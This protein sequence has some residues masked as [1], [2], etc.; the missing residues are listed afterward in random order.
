MP[1]WLDLP[2]KVRIYVSV[3]ILAAVPILFHALKVVLFSQQDYFWVILTA[4]TLVM[5]PFS[6]SH[7]GVRSGV[8]IGD[9]FVIS[10]CMLYQV[11]SAVVA[12]I[13]YI[14]YLALLLRRRHNT[15]THRIIFNIATA[16]INVQLYGAVYKSLIPIDH[17]LLPTF[18]LAVTFFLSNSILIAIAISLSSNTKFFDVWRKNY[19]PLTLD[20]LLSACGGA[21]IYLFRNW[22]QAAPLLVAPFVGAVW[23][24]NNINRAKAVDAQ[25]RL[26]EQ[27]RHSEEQEQ[28]YLRTVETLALAVDAKDQTTYGHI[29][30][31]KAYALGLAK[32]SGVSDPNEL[33]AIET[34]ALLHDIGKLAIEDYILNKPGRLSRQEFEKMKLHATAGDEI[35]RQVQFPFPVAQ[36]VRFHHERWDGTGYPD[37]LKGEEIPVG[38]R[39]LSIADAFD[40]IRSTRPYKSAFGIDDSLE[41]LRSQAGSSYDPRLVH[42]FI[43]HIDELESAADDAARNVS[44][45]SFRKYFETV[46]NAVT[47]TDATLTVDPTSASSYEE[48]VQLVEFCT[49]VGRFLP[50]S[51]SLLI[52]ARRL[53]KIVL[54]DTCAFYVYQD[55]DSVRAEC[56]YGEFAQTLQNMR[57]GLGKGISGW[58]AA[59]RQPMLNADPALEFQGIDG[60]LASLND[61]LVV[62]LIQEG[63]CLGTISLFVREPRFYS[64]NHLSLLSVVAEQV[65]LLVRAVGGNATCA[66]DTVLDSVTGISRLSHLMLAGAPILAHVARTNTPLSLVYLELTHFSHSIALYGS[67]AGDLMLRKVADALKS[68]LRQT[69]ILVRFGPHGFIA[70]LPGVRSPLATRFVIRLQQQIKSTPISLA[71]GITS[72]ITCQAGIASYPNDGSTLLDLLQSAQK[73]VIDQSR[74]ANPLNTGSDGNVL[75]F[76]PRI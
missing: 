67:G 73:A 35:L 42:L 56:A 53:K 2:L 16:A 74:L 76:P 29:R 17:T 57:I 54:Y 63:E 34:G 58:V 31:V 18:G 14:G 12:N 1:R 5:V 21:F 72:C 50:L 75:E 46:E 70:L 45:L 4:I 33:R 48:L 60:N 3:V 71:P 24:I 19:A 66:A 65:T 28:L 68:E 69:D 55:D 23:Y 40:A 37:Q 26:Q 36:Y 49:G 11:E 10:T 20:F 27:L 15:P 51:D 44:E 32:L 7:P 38:A 9:A 43:S 61:S 47:E 62:P 52:L 41:L 59:Y 25:E 64:Q 39:I 8:T 13:L 30:R 6:V 22:N